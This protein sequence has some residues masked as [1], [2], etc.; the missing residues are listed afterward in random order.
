[1][2]HVFRP[3]DRPAGGSGRG[4]RQLWDTD[5]RRYLDGA[6]AI[7]VGIGHGDASVAAAI[8]DQAARVAYARHH[9]PLR[10]AGGLRRRAG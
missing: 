6:G 10:A 2:S 3:G 1:M 9:V 4:L 8:A 5:G 7:V